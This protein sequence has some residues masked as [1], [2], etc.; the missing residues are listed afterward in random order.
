M[1]RYHGAYSFVS[2]DGTYFS[3]TKRGFRA[4]RSTSLGFRDAQGSKS[5]SSARI[6]ACGEF[7]LRSAE[8]SSEKV[9]GVLPLWPQSPQDKA[10][11]ELKPSVAAL[12]KHMP[13]APVQGTQ[14][15]EA[16]PHYVDSEAD[17]EDEAFRVFEDDDDDDEIDDATGTTEVE[18]VIDTTGSV[19][20]SD[21]ADESSEAATGSC[22]PPRVD[23]FV[24]VVTS[25]G[26]IAVVGRTRS[27][28]GDDFALVAALQLPHAHSSS[29]G[30]GDWD[31]G[32]GD[33]GGS[34]V[35][36]NSLAVDESGGIY[37]VASTHMHKV[38]WLQSSEAEQVNGAPPGKL[39]LAWSTRCGNR[40]IVI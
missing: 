39:A 8:P 7:T 28:V 12:L 26:R 32:S 1:I 14:K 31:R 23:E 35:V 40:I 13:S 34:G 3:S 24:A 2:R 22:V 10:P 18:V 20:D 36:S 33:G 9:V 37:V 30:G 21:S 6:L 17:N 16:L 4:Y 19:V 27:P 25:S 11:V 38:V 29:S 15:A 5:A